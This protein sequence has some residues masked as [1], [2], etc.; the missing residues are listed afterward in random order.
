MN[1]SK[2]ILNRLPSA[3]TSMKIKNNSLNSS[4]SYKKEM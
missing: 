1:Y 4:S 2:T 3:N